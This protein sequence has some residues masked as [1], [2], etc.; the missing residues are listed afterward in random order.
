M[1]NSYVILTGATGAIGAE[2]ARA[3]ASREEKIILA[4]RNIDKAN[5]LR[6][7][8]LELNDS[9]TIIVEELNL[10]EG[11][12]INEFVNRLRHSSINIYALINNAGSMNRH[13]ST[14]SA[15]IETTMAINYH[16]TKLLTEL[17]IEAFPSLTRIVFTTSMTRRMASHNP[18]LEI[19]PGSFSQLGTYARSKRAITDFAA[20]LAKAYPNIMVNCADPGIVNSSMIHMDRWFDRLADIAFRPF[21]RSAKHGAIPTLRAFDATTSGHIYCRYLTYS[22][23]HPKG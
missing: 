10:S 3:L 18:K 1:N 19:T 11:A 14:N 15:G 7:Q 17:L 23:P 5:K 8:L 20:E 2:I 16:N 22:L 13:F 21:I 4:C 6:Q 12:G 9:L